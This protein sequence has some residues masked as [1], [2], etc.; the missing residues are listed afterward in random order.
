MPVVNTFLPA[1]AG[2]AA[3]RYGISLDRRSVSYVLEALHCR[4]KR[5][6]FDRSSCMGALNALLGR[7][8][9]ARGQAPRTNMSVRAHVDLLRRVLD[10]D[11]SSLKVVQVAGSKGKGSTCA[12]VEHILH[13]G[14]G[15]KTGLFTSPHL[16]SATERFR[17]NTDPVSEELFVE[18]FWWIW[19][20]LYEAGITF[21]HDHFPSFFTFFTLMAVRIFMQQGV[22]IAILEV[23]IGGR[24]DSTTAVIDNLAACAISVLDYDHTS[25][26]GNTLTQIAGEKAAVM[27][28]GLPA[29]IIEQREEVRPQVG[30]AVWGRTRA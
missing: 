14:F 18:H 2:A 7:P 13:K 22:E 8:V 30:W 1:A 20:K 23:G 12:F 26:L 9:F 21:D 4:K 5:E 3:H 6:S 19:D 29:C 16:V 28:D 25:M 10:I 17:I 24:L 27:R 11:T 15:V